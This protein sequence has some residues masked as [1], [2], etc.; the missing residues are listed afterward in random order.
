MMKKMK[1][2]H[3]TMN[4]NELSREQLKNIFGGDGSDTRS[5]GFDCTDKPTMCHGLC[6]QCRPNSNQAGHSTCRRDY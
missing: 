5:C 1:L 6:S 3:S 2:S 4:E